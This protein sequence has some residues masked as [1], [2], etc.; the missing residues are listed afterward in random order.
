MNKVKVILII[1]AIF[2]VG[3]FNSNQEKVSIQK[4]DKLQQT[5]QTYW[6]H[7]K[8]GEFEKAQLL[9][10]TPPEVFSSCMA[11]SIKECEEELKKEN[12]SKS[13]K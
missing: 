9:I 10:T 1:S 5:F 8:K 6:E 7:S 13:I 2:L 11:L 4:E 3:C 12:K